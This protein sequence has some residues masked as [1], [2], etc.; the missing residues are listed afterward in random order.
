MQHEQAETTESRE[1]GK[2]SCGNTDIATLVSHT[3]S[4]TLCSKKRGL[5]KPKYSLKKSLDEK[6]ITQK[7]SFMSLWR[8]Y[9]YMKQ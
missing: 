4:G 6:E 7:N 8:V 9:V 2:Q 1:G 3:P 5:I